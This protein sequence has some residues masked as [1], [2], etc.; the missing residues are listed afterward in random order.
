MHHHHKN[1]WNVLLLACFMLSGVSHAYET[2][3]NKQ[4]KNYALLIGINQYE[5]FPHLQSPRKNVETLGNILIKTFDFQHDSVIKITDPSSCSLKSIE[6]KLIDLGKKMTEND[7]LIIYF[8][9]HS[10]VDEN[11]E[12]YWIPS[13]GKKLV[14]T[15]FSH[16]YL[17]DTLIARNLNHIPHIMVISEGYF[18]EHLFHKNYSPPFIPE[19]EYK[20]WLIKNSYLA[21]REIL[22]LNDRYWDH[23][24]KTQGLGLFAFYL[25]QAINKIE[26]RR[27][28]LS[29]FL[30]NSDLIHGPIPAITGVNV[31]YGRLKNIGDQGGQLIIQKASQ[32]PLVNISQ[33]Q[34]NPDIGYQGDN[35]LISCETT[36]PASQVSI[37][38]NGRYYNMIGIQKNWRYQTQIKT[39]GKTI[40]QITPYN[41]ENVKGSTYQG[42]LETVLPT[43]P[44][45]N[46]IDSRVSPEKGRMGKTFHFYATTDIPT[47]HVD[48]YIDGI[49]HRMLGKNKNWSFRKSID[50]IGLTHFYIV[51]SN[52]SGVIGQMQRGSLETTVPP[53][54]VTQIKVRPDYG[55]IGDTFIFT[56]V[57]DKKAAEV[58]IDINNERYA[59][60]GHL[61]DWIY[62]AQINKPGLID[63]K[64][65]ALNEVK[66][67]GK[68]LS[69]NFSVSRKPLEIP[70]I[71]HLSVLPDTI[72]KSESILVHAQTSS[73]AR[74]V[75][76]SMDNQKDLFKGNNTQWFYKTKIHKPQNLHVRIVAKNHR[77]MQGM[78]QDHVIR[79]KEV[80]FDIIKIIHAEVN[81]KK[82]DAG[83]DVFFQILTDKPAK[84]VNLILDN[85]QLPMNGQAREWQLTQT[86]DMIGT[87][88]FAII[89]VDDRRVKGMSYIDHIDV[90]AGTPS[91]KSIRMSPE[92]PSV[93]ELVTIH[94]KTDKP[95][96]RVILQM[97]NI[98]YPMSG[99]NRD[100]YFKHTFYSNKT[101]EFTI[102]PYNL[103]NSPGHSKNGKVVV[104]EPKIPAPQV[105]TV[106][107]KSMETGFFL[108]ETLLFSVQTDVLAK[109]CLLTLN[110]TTVEMNGVDKTWYFAGKKHQKGSNQYTI[111]AFN[112]KGESGKVKNGQFFIKQKKELPVNVTK[113]MVH[114]LKGLSGQLF[115]FSAT[116]DRPASNVKLTIADTVYE[117]AGKGLHWHTQ[118][119]GYIPGENHF[120]VAALNSSA[121]EGMLKTGVFTVSTKAEPQERVIVKEQSFI[122]LPPQDRFVDH[123]NGTVTDKST[124]LMWAKSPKTM[125]ETFDAAIN[126]CRY[127]NI[128]GLT[129]WRLPTI[130]EW[131]RLV[132][133]S[134][135]NPAL[136]PEHPFEAIHTGIG[137]WTKT[138]HRFGPKYVHQMK[139]WYGKSGY[140]KKTQRALVWPVRYAGF[141]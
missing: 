99:E 25:T 105:L 89:P 5:N 82:C 92:Q 7:Q 64:V 101:F 117:M 119:N 22:A 33:C 69:G 96:K 2:E 61:R 125:P 83:T 134:Q 126:Y 16:K 77:G 107:I 94:V 49:R 87:L 104:V 56:S 24:I 34:T 110:D 52:N 66:R 85:N 42:F 74:M 138:P 17:V 112:Q 80:P 6:K 31:A 36:G 127:L 23:N 88:Y 76:M 60:Q 71:V 130:D 32:L 9:G 59:M 54:N 37:K 14:N 46:V 113:V 95:A 139:L 15:W 40:F 51:T 29:H 115:Q 13:D 38:I 106:D 48:L 128:N 109:R 122:P 73:P 86:I 72:Y 97:D 53:V 68:S 50:S 121:V 67:K 18:S 20:K 44:V 81:P 131:N 132:D 65:V 78:A 111:Q 63:Y 84:K 124:R 4:G 136:P 10:Q 123:N 79:V 141:D 75:Y 28:A 108:N 118:I 41:L 62:R 102:K 11:G 103:K 116:T 27:I 43:N 35:F 21:S 30:L 98:L 47:D 100:F 140:M 57:T 114:P 137:Y 19:V 39:P 26:K 12:T 3:L 55:Y 135:K 93:N 8:S 91:I 1:I 70:D 129:N 90:D 45:C 133:Q 120:Y 58:L